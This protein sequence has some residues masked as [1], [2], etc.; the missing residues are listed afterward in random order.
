LLE[1]GL[2]ALTLYSKLSIHKKKQKKSKNFFKK[3]KK[4]KKTLKKKI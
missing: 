4:I 2:Q 3:T 1:F